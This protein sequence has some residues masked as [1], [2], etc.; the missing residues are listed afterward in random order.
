MSII[1]LFIWFRKPKKTIHQEP[2]TE[3]VS[4]TNSVN[5]IL[6]VAN[7]FCEACGR[8][9]YSVLRN[10]IWD[11]FTTYFGLTGS[12]MNK[13]SLADVLQKKNIDEESQKAIV[14]I[15]DRCE[16]GIFTNA[17]ETGDSRQLLDGTK[18]VLLKI[19]T[20]LRS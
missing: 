17:G 10:C 12:K 5:G 4:A 1:G 13:A 2:M 9:F 7:T 15:L 18:D 11:F 8:T 3:N 6:Q 20:Q 14:E 16:A 19:A